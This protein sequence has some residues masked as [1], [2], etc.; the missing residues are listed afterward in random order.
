VIRRIDNDATAH[1]RGQI[2]LSLVDALSPQY[3]MQLDFGPALC[4]A[5]YG[6]SSYIYHM[7]NAPGQH[8]G[9]AHVSMYASQPFARPHPDVGLNRNAE[10]CARSFTSWL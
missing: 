5:K 7:G 1:P 8:T 10:I 2:G 3:S 4:V 9:T 6:S